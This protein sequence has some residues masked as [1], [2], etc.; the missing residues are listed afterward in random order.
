MKKD[1]HLI[2]VVGLVIIVLTICGTLIYINHNSWTFRF[3]MDNNTKEA[4][5]SIG[6]ENIGEKEIIF[7]DRCFQRVIQRN[8]YIDYNENQI[9]QY[10][11][12]NTTWHQVECSRYDNY[13]KSQSE[14]KK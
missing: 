8:N 6:F 13:S 14:D 2:W 11:D 12:S 9:R 1:K 5:E 3:E 10:Y 7:S 4:I